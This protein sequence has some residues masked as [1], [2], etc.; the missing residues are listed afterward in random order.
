VAEKVMGESVTYSE[1]IFLTYRLTSDG[2]MRT[3]RDIPAYSAAVTFGSVILEEM[4]RHEYAWEL[5]YCK[6]GVPPRHCSFERWEDDHCYHIYTGKA[7]EIS[8]AICRAAILALE[9]AD[10]E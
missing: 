7:V 10:S 1:D 6:E 4:E 9:E 5:V 2:S 8:L 3:Y